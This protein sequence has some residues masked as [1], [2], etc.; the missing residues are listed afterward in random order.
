MVTIRPF[1]GLRPRA[2]MVERIAAPPYDVLDTEEARTIIAGNPLSFLQVSKAEAVLPKSIDVHSTEVYQTA[3]KNFR[4]F[5]AEGKL[6]QDENPHYYL[7]EQAAGNCR[8][9]GLVACASVEEYVQNIIKKHELTRP[10]KEQDRVNH[11]SFTEA[12]S[13][14]V[15]LVHKKNEQVAELK[16]RIMAETNPVYDFMAADGVRNTL[17]VVENERDIAALTALFAR[18]DNLYIADGHHRSAAAARVADEAR[19]AWSATS[20]EVNWF[21]AVIFPEDEVTVLPYNRL[22]RDLNGFATKDVLLNLMDTF[23]VSAITEENPEPQER[24]AFALYLGHKWYSLKL[25]EEIV[26][27]NPLDNLDATILQNNVLGPFWGINDPR[28]DK[29]IA[30]IGGNRT[31]AEVAAKVDSGEFAA[32]FLLFPT[33]VAELIEV[34]DASLIMPPKS[35]WFEPKLLDAIVVHLIGDDLHG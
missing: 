13:G 11:I 30:F 25:R 27:E 35:T 4:R 3:Q 20:D 17:Y 29:R 19:K 5:I 23:I 24:H 14:P 28:T 10:D 34:A 26:S 21:L 32:A 31:A 22:L 1:R 12:Q 16:E 15:F 18:L 8:Q 33:S 7:Y 9:I 6:L 2:D